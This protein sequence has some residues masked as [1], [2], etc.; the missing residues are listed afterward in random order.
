MPDQPIDRDALKAHYIAERGYWR[1]WNEALLQHNPAFLQRYADYAGHPARTGPLSERMVELIYVALD[2]SA[3][4]LFP[5]GLEIHMRKALEVGATPEDIF[6]VLH[7][8]T[9]QGLASVYDAT[10]ILAEEAGLG[11]ADAARV[12]GEAAPA[13]ADDTHRDE[14]GRPAATASRVRHLLPGAERWLP[15]VLALDP[16]YLDVLLDFLE[17]G[18]P[19]SGLSQADRAVIDVALHACFTAYRPAALRH[20]IRSA[21]DAGNEP[22][23][24]LQA[25][26][27][28]AHLS[29]HGAALG[30]STYAGLAAKA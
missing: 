28:G 18:R 9:A 1:P 5:T 11:E 29:V 20:A 23:A 6:D 16:G 3:T 8:V 4:H 13:Q 30:A 25:I 15:A 24:L 2:S 22:A 7:L 21:L 10:A 26:Q 12:I 19:Q 17:H 27:L 14:A